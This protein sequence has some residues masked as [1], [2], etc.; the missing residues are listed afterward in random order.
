ME[1][2]KIQWLSSQGEWLVESLNAENT[3]GQTLGQWAE[4]QPDLTSVRL[5]LS[6]ANYSVHWVSMPGVNNRH[7]ARALPF[8]L[9]EALIEDVAH[10]LIVP[11]GQANKKV[12]AY[13]VASELIERLLEECEHHHLKVHDLIPETRL[14]PDR[15]LICRSVFNHHQDAWLINLPGV[16]EGWVKETALTPVL[17]SVL[18]GIEKE[19]LSIWAASLDQAK[20]L[21]TN[22][23]TGFIDSFE[24]IELI[25]TDGEQQLQAALTEKYTSLLTGA[26]EKREHKEN[27]PAAWWRPLLAMSAVWLV[28]VAIYLLAENRLLSAQERM[29]RQASINLYKQLF[30]GERVRANG[31]ERQFKEKLSSGSSGS[32]KGF[33]NL[34]NVTAQTYADKRLQEKLQLQSIRFN[35]RLQELIVEVK[36]KSLNELQTLKQALEAQG[37]DAEVSSASNDETGV[38]GRLKIGG[39]A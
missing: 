15:N 35:E 9:E 27:K 19:Q 11:S 34:V 7:L 37:I 1:T 4:N 28:L 32:Q 2:I 12:R 13:A 30:P 29:V 22:I 36:A 33:L 23:E 14:L 38:K 3:S 5:I 21:K 17:E 20:L 39:E 26:F 10:Y 24:E 31:L 18:P 25:A 16:F 6:A 8:A